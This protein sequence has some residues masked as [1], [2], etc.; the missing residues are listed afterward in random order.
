MSDRIEAATWLALGAITNSALE[1]RGCEAEHLLAVL[2]VF[3]QMG[4]KVERGKRS[5][6]VMPGDRPSG[7]DVVTLPFPA[8]PTDAQAQLMALATLSAGTSV[9]TERI[10]PERF[11]HA[12]E[13]K[14]MGAEISVSQGQAVVAG[15]TRLQGAEV[16]ASDLRASAG[17][18]LAAAAA[19]GETLI[20]RIYHIDR[21]YECIDE[22]LRDVGMAI[23]RVVE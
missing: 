1:V 12:A 20:R 8:F 9:I 15:V 14:R 13:M 4:I 16:M 5:L 3:K 6:T 10:Y 19:E 23:E 2:H 21:G 18:V 7:C 11:M 22:R 17:L